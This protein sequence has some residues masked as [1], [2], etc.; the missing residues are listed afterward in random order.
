MKRVDQQG[1]LGALAGR[2]GQEVRTVRFGG[3]AGKVG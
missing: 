2:V 3:V 1:C